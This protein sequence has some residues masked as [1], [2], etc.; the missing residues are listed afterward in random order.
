MLAAFLIHIVANGVLK[1]FPP[2]DPTLDQLKTYLSEEASTW[3][4]VHGLRYVAFACIA[5]FAAALF[6]RTCRPLSAR[7]TGWGVLGL[8]GAALHVTNGIVTNGIEILAFMDFH[9]LSEDPKLFWL[10]FYLTRILFTGEIVAWGLLIGGF[11]AAGW[12]SS[13]LPRWLTILGILSAIGALACG[14][15][16]VSIL[17]DGS[18]AGVLVEIASIGCLAWFLITGVLMV[19]QGASSKDGAVEQ[20]D[21]DGRPLRGRL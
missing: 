5:L 21:A 3:A 8:L 10:V 1:K 20:G 14:V 19:L 9:Q 16:I 12:H 2:D 15:F 4:L 13:T 6:L 17:S 7:S 18:A 11:S